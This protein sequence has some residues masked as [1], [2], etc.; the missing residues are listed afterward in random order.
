MFLELERTKVQQFFSYAKQLVYFK[1]VSICL[2]FGMC[3]LVF[4]Q[5]VQRIAAIVNDEIIS[6]FDLDNR[7]RLVAV[8]ANLPP[9][10]DIYR[11]LRHQVLRKMIDERLQ[12]QEAARLKISV[13]QREINR[14]IENLARRNRLTMVQMWQLLNQ[15]QVDRLA[16]ETQVRASISWFKLIDRRLARKVTVG[17]DEVAEALE[18]Y[19]QELGRPKLR[20][21]EIFLSVDR[22]NAELSI[23]QTAEKL[24]QQIVGGARFAAIAREFSDSATAGQGGDLGWITDSGLDEEL[25]RAIVTMQPGQI[26]SPI[27]TLTGY[28]ILYLVDRR[29]PESTRTTSE[30][31]FR[32]LTIPLLPNAIQAEIDEKTRHAREVSNSVRSCEEFLKKGRELEALDVDRMQSVSTGR[33]TGAFRELLMTQDLG[34]PSTPRRTA[35]GI[36]II[37]VCE[38]IVNEDG[39]PTENELG[40]RIRQ[41]RINLL[42]QRYMRDLRRAA[43]LDLRQ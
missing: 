2:Y 13:K 27:R 30:I 9:Q 8:T 18:R 28:Y 20:I 6:K 22:P 26:S 32:R 33:L 17:E 14:T 29:I 37:V 15:R 1:C 10:E 25:A 4:S 31:R 5:D 24:I 42:A 39:L 36:S 38:R 43:Y 35:Q 41:Q 11:R 34:I 23:R 3:T 21:S 19:R 12:L 16:L 7:V 40:E